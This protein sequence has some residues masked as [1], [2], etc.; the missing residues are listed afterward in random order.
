MLGEW[1]ERGEAPH[2]L[3]WLG[4]IVQDIGYRNA[5]SYFGFGTEEMSLG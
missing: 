4:G 1:V 2:D 5:E 3:D